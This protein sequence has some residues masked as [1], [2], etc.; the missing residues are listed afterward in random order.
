MAKKSGWGRIYPN[1]RIVTLILDPVE[2][3]ELLDQA[4]SEGRRIGERTVMGMPMIA[5]GE[6][7]HGREEASLRPV[8]GRPVDPVEAAGYPG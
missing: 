7:R 3:E 8:A 4:L 5:F 6:P 1:K 2:A